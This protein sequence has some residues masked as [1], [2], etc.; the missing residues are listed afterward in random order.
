MS[1]R[2]GGASDARSEGE[3]CSNFKRIFTGLCFR[4]STRLGWRKKASWSQWAREC[5]KKPSEQQRLWLRRTMKRPL[6]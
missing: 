5:R 4:V 2:Q 3:G 6:G 1:R